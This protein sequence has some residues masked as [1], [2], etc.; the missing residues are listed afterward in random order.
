MAD[1]IICPICDNVIRE[2]TGRRQGHDA[3]ECSGVC[4][5]WLHRHCAGLSK[6]AFSSV[7]TSD[8]PFYCPQCRLDKQ[9]L[10]IAALCELVGKLST[11][12]DG[13]MK[14]VSETAGPALDVSDSNSPPTPL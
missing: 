13:L 6:E 9:E 1:N 3:V 7:S 5:S 14:N 10:E 4:S 11:K 12:L 8:K 2:S